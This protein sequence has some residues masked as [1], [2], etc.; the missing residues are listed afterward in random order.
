MLKGPAPASPR[1]FAI[2]RD[3]SSDNSSQWTLEVLIAAS[4]PRYDVYTM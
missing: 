3:I 1:S 2:C 4:K